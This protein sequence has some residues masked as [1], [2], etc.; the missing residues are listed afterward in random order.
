MTRVMG[1]SAQYLNIPA[2]V[3]VAAFYGNGA[4]AATI[5]QAEARFPHAKYGRCWIDVLGTLPSA[6]ARDW[7][8]GD[9]GG[10]LEQW[11]IDH[12]KASGRKD[13]VVYCNVSTIPEVRQL[14][15]TQVLGTDYFLWVATLDGT[16]FGP[17]QYAH[18]IAN[19]I[20]GAQLT[21]G[22]WDESLV[23]DASFWL[24]VAP[25]APKPAAPKVTQAQAKA[26]IASAM[27]A[28]ATLTVAIPELP[29]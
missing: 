14:T 4:Y 18:V 8:T 3:Q 21:K 11:V 17:A 20:K 6:Q 24:P 12:N 25:A 1:D 2:S 27:T 16:L 15:G 26:A 29:N 10:S 28:L 7:E 22:D 13:A 9:K 5:A 19:Q 23:F